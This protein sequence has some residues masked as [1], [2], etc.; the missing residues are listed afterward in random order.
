MLHFSF[1]LLPFFF[2]FLSIYFCYRRKKKEQEKLTQILKHRIFFSLQNI[3]T[4]LFGLPRT[5]F[6]LFIKWLTM[7][8][9]HFDFTKKIILLIFNSKELTNQLYMMYWYQ[10]IRQAV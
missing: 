4:I 8:Y 5:S 9:F 6:T 1:V 10:E 2:F 7:I 3:Q